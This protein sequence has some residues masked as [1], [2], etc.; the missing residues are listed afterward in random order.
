MGVDFFFLTQNLLS[1]TKVICQQSLIPIEHSQKLTF[2]LL[3]NYV[4]LYSEHY[5]KQENAA[6][7][8]FWCFFK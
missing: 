8:N 1:L 4:A 3:Q 2:Y 5:L 6:Y 7:I